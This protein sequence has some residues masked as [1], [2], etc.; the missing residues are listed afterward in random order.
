MA[1]EPISALT[2][3]TSYS[4][5]DEVEILDVSDTTFASTGTNK[6]IQFSTL[7]TMAGVGTTATGD[8]T[9]AP[10]SSTRN[11]IQP[12][13]DY[14]A[15]ALEASASQT[16]HLQEWQNSSGTA[17]AY[18]DSKGNINTPTVTATTGNIS[19]VN[20]G[21]EAGTIASPTSTTLWTF[22]P[23]DPA[24]GP[25]TAVVC[26]NVFGTIHDSVMFL[27]YNSGNGGLPVLAGEPVWRY[28]QEQD[29][30]ISGTSAHTCEAYQE[31]VSG[32]ISTRPWMTTLNRATG[33]ANTTFDI[34]PGGD[35]NYG[36]FVVRSAQQTLVRAFGGGTSTTAT[37]LTLSQ[38]T[39]GQDAIRLQLQTTY[40]Y[41][42]LGST[43]A[44]G[45]SIS[46]GAAGKN[47]YLNF[48]NST[49]TSG[50]TQQVTTG[51]LTFLDNVHSRTH[52]SC[53]AGA[54]N[55]AA[56]T[57]FAC[58]V[59]VDGSVGFYGRTPI[60]QPVGGGGNATTTAAGS[61]TNVFTN[62]S[63]PGASGS[64]AYTIGDIVTALKALGLLTP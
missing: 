54:S 21:I 29:Y 6:R 9:L 3:F 31:F 28:G 10:G 46:I 49:A 16:H 19:K 17:L 50:W 12:T 13:G 56:L 53:T 41:L 57:E 44:I 2:L 11:V 43:A 40:A 48:A 33:C 14:I 63:F 38:A 62:T 60:V 25:W 32:S 51:P 18:V 35:T 22:Q 52:F 1:D 30:W 58:S 15:L 27:G 36:D 7:L 23:T 55:A 64:S 45:G 42:L 5:A 47:A 20:F 4:T 34:G 37:Y 61:T 39:A 24:K 8:V 26:D 59:K